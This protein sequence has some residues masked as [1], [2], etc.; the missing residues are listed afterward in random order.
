MLSRSAQGLY[1]M[2][3]YL[4]RAERLC[5]LLQLQT[6]ALVD[7]PIREIHFGWSRIYASMERQPPEGSLS[8]AGDDFVLADSY[9]L[10]DDLTFDRLN[11]CSVWNCFALGR[12]NARQVRH[13]ISPEMWTRLNVAFLRI[14]SL[15]ILDIWRE[16][17]E[18]FYAE[19]AAE[20]ATFAGVA[21]A[22]MYRDEGWRFMQ[23]GR[24]VEG[25]QLSSGLL[26][27]QL[28]TAAGMASA[29]EEDADWASLLRAC[30]AFDACK[31]RHGVDA[32]PGDV[33]D[34]LAADPWLPNS[35]CRSLDAAAT[36]LDAIGPGPGARSSD[37]LR[38]L[39]GRLRAMIHYEWPDAENKEAFL[40]QAHARC[41]EL[42]HL[43][44]AAYFDYP[45]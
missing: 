10:A 15:D 29:E 43:L 2:G 37:A 25:A 8:F 38:R 3:R 7:R 34:L 36:E 39:A 32:R 5:R 4:Q 9:T 16:S 26:L 12:E 11:P 17:P 28:S 45:V 19:T 21:E 20:I 33:L 42:H 13:C 27:A 31:R 35:L 30:H 22:T 44:T 41:R 6:A 24:S 18:T 1:W 23:L 14:Q 40:R